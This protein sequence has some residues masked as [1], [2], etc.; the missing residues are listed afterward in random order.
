[1]TKSNGPKIQPCGT[2]G[3]RGAQLNLLNSLDPF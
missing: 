2:P 3:R 1:M